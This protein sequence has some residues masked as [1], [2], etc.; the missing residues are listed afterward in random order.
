M[1]ANLLEASLEE[2][3]YAEGVEPSR[4]DRHDPVDL[5]RVLRRPAE[6]EERDR[7]Q[8]CAP[9][10]GREALLRYEV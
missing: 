1:T 8:E 5:R 7:Q 10:G 9:H 3:K 4:D 2:P 6:P